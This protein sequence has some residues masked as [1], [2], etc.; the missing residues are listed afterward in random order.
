MV[1]VSVTAAA[2]SWALADCSI[3]PASNSEEVDARALVVVE[4]AAS[5]SSSLPT[6]LWN[7]YPISTITTIA[8]NAPKMIMLR[9]I[10]L[11]AVVALLALCEKLPLLVLHLGDH[12]ADVVHVPLAFAGQDQLLS[13]LEAFFATQLRS[14]QPPRALPRPGA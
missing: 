12:F 8:A 10:A 3:V 9:V 13:G 6:I 4:T 1:T 5:N 2:C 11:P 14:L 7:E